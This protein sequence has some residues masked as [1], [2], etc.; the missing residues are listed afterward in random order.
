MLL[1]LYSLLLIFFF[2]KVNANFND[3]TFSW[4]EEWQKFRFDIR[5]ASNCWVVCKFH[6]LPPLIV[7]NIVFRRIDDSMFP[8]SLKVS[9]T[10][11]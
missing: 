8:L 5:N 4:L 1:S 11:D 10:E 6:Y 2:D 3:R 7:K 9:P